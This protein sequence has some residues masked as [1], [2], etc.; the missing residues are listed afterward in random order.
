MSGGQ[1]TDTRVT[2]HAHVQAAIAKAM[3]A[4][5]PLT[6]AQADVICRALGGA[7]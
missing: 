5:P 7:S 6:A 2:D 3:A 4:A 1:H